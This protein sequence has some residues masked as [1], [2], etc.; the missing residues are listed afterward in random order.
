MANAVLSQF[1]ELGIASILLLTLGATNHKP[2]TTNHKPQTT[3]HNVVSYS[4]CHDK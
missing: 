3:N 1:M 2:Q 4:S